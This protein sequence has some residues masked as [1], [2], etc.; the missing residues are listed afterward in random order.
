MSALLHAEV[1]FAYA[2]NVA[3]AHP[4]GADDARSVE[5]RAVRRVEVLHP[6]AV[7]ARLDAGVARGGELVA[8][9]DEVVLTAASDG[10][11]RGADR[12]HRIGL[13]A[14]APLHDEVHGTPWASCSR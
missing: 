11:R 1:G 5:E 9:E 12:E 10:D 4:L 7:A 14:R 13:E 3:R 8:V 6:D 2:E